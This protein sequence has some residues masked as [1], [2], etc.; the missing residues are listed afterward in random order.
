[1]KNY[2]KY[3]LSNLTIVLIA[4]GL[5][6]VGYIFFGNFENGGLVNKVRYGEAYYNMW[7][8]ISHGS[9]E[10]D[11]RYISG[12]IFKVD[13]KNIAYFLPLP[14]F[15][16]ALWSLVDLG[17]YPMPSILSGLIIY[18]LGIYLLLTEIM[19]SMNSRIESSDIKFLY[20]F[21]LV[22]ISSLYVEASIYWEAIIWGLAIF[23]NLL[24]FYFRY[25]RDSRLLNMCLFQFVAVLCLFTRP[26]Y[27]FASAV[28]VML[29]SFFDINRIRKD[30]NYSWRRMLIA[31]CPYTIFLIGVLSLLFLNYLRWGDVFEFSPLRF[32]EQLIGTERGRLAS[33]N[34]ALSPSRI[35]SSLVYYFGV[36]SS[37]IKN[38][39]PYIQIDTFNAGPGIYYDY[40]EHRISFLLSLPFHIAVAM[41]SLFSLKNDINGA[42]SNYAN[43]SVILIAFTPILI[44]LMA[45]SLAIRYR[46]EFY[47]LLIV[48]DMFLVVRA[49]KCNRSLTLWS[50][51][52][53]SVISLLIVLNSVVVERLSMHGYENN[54]PAYLI[55]IYTGKIN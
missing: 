31:G 45:I 5:V 6:F 4:V 52:I 50:I 15:V 10:V 43:I 21:F 20:L 22:P 33:I 38:I 25:I 14:A 39:F 8:N 53:I 40:I 35:I 9:V 47:P 44:I 29:M 36:S 34:P 13:G 27:A 54:N 24:Y 55:K 28:A 11:P 7:E 30:C 32:H 3:I 1:M 16:R 41:I 19:L 2:K 42:R 17:E 46:S 37:G 51:L 12:E 18:C 48:L 26:T 49:L 23:I